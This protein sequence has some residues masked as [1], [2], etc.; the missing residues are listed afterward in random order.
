MKVHEPDGQVWR[1]RRRWLPWRRRLR[2][3]FP[4]WGPSNLGDDPISAVIGVIVLIL[5]LPFILLAIVVSLELL[6]LLLLVPFVALFRIVFGRQWEVDVRKGRTLW[7][8]QPC[9]SWSDSGARIEEIAEAIRRGR[10]PP[11]TISPNDRR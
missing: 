7:W 10:T 2:T 3:Y 5:M 6:L 1:V 8:S 11:R 9:G 4:D